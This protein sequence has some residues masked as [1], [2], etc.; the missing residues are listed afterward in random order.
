MDSHRRPARGRFAHFIAI[1]LSTVVALSLSP[2]GSAVAVSDSGTST[3]GVSAHRGGAG[4]WPENS[5]KAFRGSVA[6]GYDMIET[7]VQFTSDFV[8]VMS[9]SDTLPS[10]CT[11]SGSK[12]HKLTYAKVSAVRCDGE[13]IPTLDETISII[14]GS[15]TRLKVEVK[16]Y[17]GQSTSSKLRYATEATRRLV[18]GGMLGQSLMHTFEWKVM[19]PAIHA[20]AP[21]MEVI[22]LDSSPSLAEVRQAAAAKIALY[23]PPA[24]K[25]GEFLLTYVKSLGMQVGLYETGTEADLKYALDMGVNPLSSDRPED[26]R[27][28]LKTPVAELL[29]TKQVVVTNRSPYT[30]SSATY[31]AGSSRTAKILG[32][33]VPSSKIKGLRAAILTVAVTSGT[34]VGTI[35]FSPYVSGALIEGVSVPMPTGSATLTVRVS[36]GDSGKIR[37]VTGSKAKLKVQVIGYEN[38]TY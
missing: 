7:D 31:S 24:S 6:A 15:A 4:Q 32:S 30:I 36:P 35:D 25:T 10:R 37:I 22:A 26:V 11:S 18:D 27:N 1:T 13:P 16:S 20:V 28:W 34:G 21:S 14:K 8:P 5:A 12:I 29:S 3:V 17:S 9:H 33:A 23:A 38:L 19:A 2:V